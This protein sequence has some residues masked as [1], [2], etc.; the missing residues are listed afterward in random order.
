MA[1][2]T[3]D[4]I[5]AVKGQ[6]FLLNRGTDCFS[7]RIVSAAGEFTADQLTAM[8]EVARR[9]GS[10]RLINTARQC[11]EIPGIPF[12]KIPEAKGYL[13]EHGCGIAFGGTGA[14]I[15]PVVS[16]KGTTC[17]YGNCDT[18]GI[19]RRIHEE[20]YLGKSDLKLPHKFKIA[21]GGCPNSCM[22]P[23]I[24]DFGIEGRRVPVIDTAL[25][26]GCAKCAVET[27]CPSKVAHVAD[28]RIVIGEDC[29]SCG[30]CV[31]KCPFG[32]I[33]KTSE[34][35]YQIYVGG[36]W[37]KKRRTGTPLSRLVTEEEIWTLLDRSLAWFAA[38]ANAGE[39]FGAAID[40]VGIDKLEA[41]LFA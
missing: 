5:K 6:G 36:T 13:D 4:Q 15:R 26:R 38:N 40:R 39:R 19:A 11:V 29:L 7:G 25:C 9:F 31:G 33:A 3:P 8:A 23:S 24:N 37:G 32:A 10:G 27:S 41:Y 20:Y 35:V 2:L 22:K 16:C 34:T 18:L 1:N 14:K 17:V 28:G 12:D 21:V 30:V